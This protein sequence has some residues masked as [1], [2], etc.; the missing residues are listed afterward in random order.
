[1]LARTLMSDGLTARMNEMERLFDSLVPAVAPAFAQTTPATGRYPAFNIWED[2]AN[3]Y[4]EAELPGVRSDHLEI[5]ATDEE[6]TIRGRR[7]FELPENARALRQERAVGAFERTIGLP[8]EIQ[9]DKIDAT[10]H[11]GVLRI[12]MPKAESLQP[13]KIQVR[14]EG[15]SA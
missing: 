8:Y 3:L 15:P 13:R 14:S 11:D 6:L 12:T 9:V 7:E 1:M 4:A 2:D 10:L 5:D